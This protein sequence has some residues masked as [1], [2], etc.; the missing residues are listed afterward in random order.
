LLIILMSLYDDRILPWLIDVSLRTRPVGEQR[1]ALLARLA[2]N[3]LEIGFGTG[4]S[5]RYYPA[6]V[7]KLYTLD[8]GHPPF[9]RVAERI[10]AAPFPVEELSFDPAR[11]YPLADS[12]V[13]AVASMFTLCTVP[14]PEDVMREVLRVLK[15]GGVFIFLEHGLHEGPVRA[16][17]QHRLTPVWRRLFGGCHLDRDIGRVVSS[18]GLSAPR[19]ERVKVEGLPG[20]LGRLYRGE[21]VKAGA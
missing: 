7:R 10:A 2:G 6:A 13:D 11:P 4:L 15:P 16:A 21:A 17:W 18:A 1:A 9:K 8:P 20:L 12:S 3:V 19:C 14:N 5:L